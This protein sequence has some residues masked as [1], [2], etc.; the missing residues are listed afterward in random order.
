MSKDDV[1][2]LNDFY[3]EEVLLCATMKFQMKD[4]ESLLVPLKAM[5]VVLRG[6]FMTQKGLKILRN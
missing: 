1:F 5:K 6:L 4:C 3:N 2:E